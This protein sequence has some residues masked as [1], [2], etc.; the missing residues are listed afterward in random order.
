MGSP[1]SYR[2]SFS[3]GRKWAIAF[4]VIVATAAVF[5]ILIGVNY[6]S[7]RFA[8]KRFY[9]S[10]NSRIQLSPR[11]IGLLRSLTN[12]VEA[13]IYYDKEEPLYGDIV[14]LLKEYQAH[15]TK[16]TIKTVDYYTDFGAAQE[17]KL[18]YADQLGAATNRDFVIF[19]CDSRHK[20]VDG[21]SLSDYHFGLK[22][23][24]DPKD[25]QPHPY[26][27]RTGFSGEEHFSA[28]IFAVTQAK[29]LN[30]YFLQGHGEHSP[31]DTTDDA[32]YGKLADV[33]HRNYVYT[34]VLNG[35]LGTNAIPADCN[36]LVIA[37]PR[38]EFSDVES[39]KIAEYLNQG[40]RL[41]ALFDVT[42]T[43]RDIGLEDILAKWNV[44]VTHSVVA[45]P[46]QEVHNVHGF[47][48]ISA[49]AIHDVTKPVLSARIGIFDP[50]PVGRIK[51]TSSSAVD[52]PQVTEL[53]FSSTNSFLT[54]NPGAGQHY[55]PLITA[56]E[57]SVAKGVSVTRGTTRMVI[58]GDS[59]FLDNQ[60]IGLNNNEDFA[61]SAINWLLDRNELL[62]GIGSRPVVSYRFSLLQNQV[63][64]VNGILLGA[65]PGGIL[66]FG[67][68]VWLRRRK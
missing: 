64:K 8:F 17:L 27:E 52:E 38:S 19:D 14:A 57:R 48:A 68:V 59:L 51:A 32:G 47:F 61:D 53:A 62:G 28:A 11:T 66:L 5:L 10:T 36:L 31:D 22:K 44:R 58:A 29:P 3:R 24:D 50:R 30:A 56:V 54:D 43:N 9:L 37:G 21:N 4:N 67:G 55:F 63:G 65:I 20:F 49:L 46:N 42:S 18:K 16:L 26:R 39:N 15:T 1:S 13:T 34:P 25:P 6:I 2:P 40:G 23:S 60:I 7:H 45:D 35:L 33:F 12:T 41:L